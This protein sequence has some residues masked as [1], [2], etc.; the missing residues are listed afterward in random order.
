MYHHPLRARSMTHRNSG[1][2]SPMKISPSAYME[3][4]WFSQS[5]RKGFNENERTAQANRF[6]QR[7]E[8]LVTAME[9]TMV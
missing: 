8:D 7:N 5:T 4:P 2:I 1:I 6:H 3:S 9:K